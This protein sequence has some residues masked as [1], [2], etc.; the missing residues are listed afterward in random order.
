MADIHCHILFGV[1][2]G[3]DSLEESRVM[4]AEEKKQGVHHIILTPH[5]R[6]GIF[7]YPIDRIHDHFNELKV[8]AK[9]LD[10]KLYLGCEYDVDSDMIIHIKGGR[11]HTLGDSEYVLVEYSRDTDYSFI[12]RTCDEMVRRGYF[13]VIAHVERYRVFQDD[14]MRLGDLRNMGCMVQV[15]ADAM[16][17]IDPGS[18]KT[19]ARAILKANLADIVASDCHGRKERACHMKK[20]YDYVKRKHGIDRAESLFVYNPLTIIDA[21]SGSE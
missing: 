4:L 16:L 20:A 6:R 15:N 7:G 13:P 8:F 19:A 14:P 11:V 1:D 18:Y 5:Y 10:L 21:I 3:S 9:I 2:D 17:G 12:M